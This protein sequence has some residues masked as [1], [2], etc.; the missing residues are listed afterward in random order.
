MTQMPSEIGA[1]GKARYLI[2]KVL[3]HPLLIGPASYVVT[4]RPTRI[5]PTTWDD[6][7]A[8]GRWADLGGLPEVPRNAVIAG[9]SRSIGRARTVLD[10]GCGEGHLLT[11]LYPESATSYMGIDVSKVAIE[12]ARRRTANQTRFEVADAATFEPSEQFDVIVLNAVLDYIAEPEQVLIH[13][14]RFLT[15]DGVFVISLVRSTGLLR[16]WRRCAAL[17][18]VIDQVRLRG[19]AEYQILLCR[20]NRR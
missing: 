15:P 6:E 12:Q 9:Y 8:A 20:P 14:G 7:Y 18:E 16:V 11:W 10:I 13:Y 19:A 4:W 3:K 17:L 5:K 1:L 2:G